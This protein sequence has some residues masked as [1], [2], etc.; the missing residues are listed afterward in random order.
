MGVPDH[1]IRWCPV[2]VFQKLALTQD[3]ADTIMNLMTSE[4]GASQ[5]SNFIKKKKRSSK[6]ISHATIY[7]QV[8]ASS[9]NSL[10]DYGFGSN[11]VLPFPPFFSHCDGYGGSNGPSVS[12]IKTLFLAISRRTVAIA[13]RVMM[14]LGGELLIFLLELKAR[15]QITILILQY[16]GFMDVSY[17]RRYVF[18]QI[19]FCMEII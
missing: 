14:S 12:A 18:I 17:M 3:L 15:M 8:M 10:N 2:V 11:S 7:L 6:Y 9:Q 19:S 13:D 1:I 4:L 16:K 5:I